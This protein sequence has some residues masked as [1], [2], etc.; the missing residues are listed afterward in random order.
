ME[1]EIFSIDP[2]LTPHKP[3]GYEE[4]ENPY[5]ARVGISHCLKGNRPRDSAT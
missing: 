4:V 2:S 1:E 3:P 5:I